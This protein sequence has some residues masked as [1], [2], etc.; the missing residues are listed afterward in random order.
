MGESRYSRQVA[1]IS[2]Y[3]DRI[4]PVAR[5]VTQEI[6]LRTADVMQNSEFTMYLDK[7]HGLLRVYYGRGKDL[8][9]TTRKTAAEEVER[10]EL[11]DPQYSFNDKKIEE[12]M[13]HWQEFKKVISDAV[14]QQKEFD[15]FT[16]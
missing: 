7:K 10:G 2:S 5:T 3:I 12:T 11:F 6:S 16:V 13:R 14:E 9:I 4:A 8:I 1:E 15:Q